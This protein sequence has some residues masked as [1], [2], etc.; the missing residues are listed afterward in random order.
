M[1]KK[2]FEIENKLK[3]VNQNYLTFIFI[4]LPEN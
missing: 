1:R 4:N 2:L 3:L